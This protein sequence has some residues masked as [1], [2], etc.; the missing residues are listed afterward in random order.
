MSKIEIT[1]Q[2]LFWW[3]STVRP[4]NEI[5]MRFCK[6]QSAHN[7]N[8][9]MKQ[10]N[11]QSWLDLLN[12]GSWDHD[13]MREHISTLVFKLCLHWGAMGANGTILQW[14]KFIILLW[15][16]CSCCVIIVLTTERLNFVLLT[17]SDVSF[18]GN[19]YQPCSKPK[20]CYAWV[21]RVLTTSILDHCSMDLTSNR[22][23]SW[24]L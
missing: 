17:M 6:N 5:F 21:L 23:L 8:F 7:W 22:L 9:Q 1:L 19:N 12:N 4:L 13:E 3:K 16:C 14:Q 18:H 2:H 20:Q 10:Q 15:I 11:F 24:C